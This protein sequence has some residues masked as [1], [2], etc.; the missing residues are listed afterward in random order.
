MSEHP[1]SGDHDFPSP[2]HPLPPAGSADSHRAPRTE[3]A[4]DGGLHSASGGPEHRAPSTAHQN[5]EDEIS[6]LDILIILAK[7][8]KLILGQIGRAHV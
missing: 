1:T 4:T 3:H 2:G 5:G 7:H 8:K 6:I